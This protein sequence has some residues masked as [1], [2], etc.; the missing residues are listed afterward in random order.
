[1]A[2]NST[3]QRLKQSHVA[4]EANIN[5]KVYEYD[6]NVARRILRFMT[7]YRGRLALGVLLMATSVFDAI[8]GP[9]LIG[10]AVD[11]GLAQGDLRLT[12]LLVFLFLGVSAISQVS[13]KF[14]IQTMVRLGQTVIRDM[15]QV[16]YD[17]LEALSA[18]FFARYEVGRLISRIMGDVQ[19]IREFI[20]FAIIAIMRDLVIVIGILLVMLAISWPLTIVVILIMPILFVFSYKWSV[21]SRKTYNEVRDLASAV[22]ARLAED[23]NGVRVVQAFARE[24]HNYRRFHDQSNREVLEANLRAARVLAVFFP[25][26][27]LLSGLALFGLVLI[28]GLLVIRNGL[29]AGV[30]IAFV[31]YIDQLFNPIRDLAQRWNVVQA[32]LASGDQVFSVLD[33]KVEIKD[34]PNAIVMPRGNGRVQFEDV[35]FSYDAK[36][37]VL[38]HIGLDVQPGQRVALVGHTGAGKTTIIKLLLRFYDVTSGC[39]RVDSHDV[40]DVTQQSLRLQMGIVLQETHLFTD[41]IMNNIRAGRDGATD[42]EVIAAATAVGAHEFITQLADGY[43]TVI[44]KGASILSVGQRQLLAFAR[45]LVA[46]PRILILDEAT[47]NIDTQTEL[48]IQKALAHL[49]AGR[50]SFII[51][52]RLSTIT[53]CD[54]IVVMDH[55][56]IIERGTHAELLAQRGVYYNL[57]TMAFNRET[58]DAEAAIIL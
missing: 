21:A 30:L 33:Q 10:R 53:G 8:F 4:A 2:T 35:T 46:D 37:P 12:L 52:H 18:S 43:Q 36:T 41:T 47:S 51:A 42:E 9:A 58:D 45:A 49:L 56:R 11:G 15:R 7:P 3:A 44:H 1:M 28:G 29:T 31:L 5:P 16:L 19:M 48:I 22:N 27:E 38:E 57:Y 26:L 20:T 17:H 50:T 13:T 25:V 54:L 23:F 24:E 32:A 39:L 14:Q 6:R 34:K 55:G 40:R